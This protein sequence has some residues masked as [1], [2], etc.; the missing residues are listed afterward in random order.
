MKLEEIEGEKE[1]EEDE[2]KGPEEIDE[3]LQE[4]KEEKEELEEELEQK[5]EE[6]EEEVEEEE[7]EM[8]EEET[9]EES[10]SISPESSVPEKQES[11][12]TMV[13]ISDEEEDEDEYEVF[14]SS[15]ECESTTSVMKVT[16]WFKLSSK[17]AA[18]VCSL[19]NNI[20]YHAVYPS[21]ML[22]YAENSRSPGFFLESL[23]YVNIK[24][25]YIVN[26]NSY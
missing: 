1:M 4:E 24:K 25:R 15:S 23:C 6:V 22:T 5:E 20:S 26:C 14:Q 2:D 8:D 11:P 18:M 7:G 10:P 17:C 12:D 3:F 19:S 13:E 16:K 9:S 21:L